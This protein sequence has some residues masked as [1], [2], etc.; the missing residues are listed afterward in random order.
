MKIHQKKKLVTFILH[1]Y[2]LHDYE[3]FDIL[4]IFFLWGKYIYV[5]MKNRKKSIIPKF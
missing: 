4:E 1:Q 3:N 2:K 5:A